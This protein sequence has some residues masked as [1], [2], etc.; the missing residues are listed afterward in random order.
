MKKKDMYKVRALFEKI[1]NDFRNDSARN[2]TLNRAELIEKSVR[3]G[4]EICNFYL[5]KMRPE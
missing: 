3:E 1:D 4:V 5:V 2:P